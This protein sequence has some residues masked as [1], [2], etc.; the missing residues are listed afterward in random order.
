M[1][2]HVYCRYYRL[3]MY[4][5]YI[6]H[7]LIVLDW[8]KPECVTHDCIIKSECWKR[9]VSICVCLMTMTV[10]VYDVHSYKFRSCRQLTRTS[11]RSNTHTHTHTHMHLT[12]AGSQCTLHGS[13]TAL[14]V[15]VA[16]HVCMRM[17]LYVCRC[18]YIQDTYI[19]M[20]FNM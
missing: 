16:M 17:Y 1:Y 8:L 4:V 2:T 10:T 11:A 13:F 14:G 9:N 3:H 5:M 12:V 7:G 15:Y 6:P 19:Q 18:E 20:H